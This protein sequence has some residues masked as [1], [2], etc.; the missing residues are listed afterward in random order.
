MAPLISM[1]NTRRQGPVAV[2]SPLTGI[3][4]CRWDTRL[5][6]MMGRQL[7]RFLASSEAGS[8]GMEGVV[9]RFSP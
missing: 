7:G 8:S 4:D 2:T 5:F 6:M 9:G 3:D 1:E